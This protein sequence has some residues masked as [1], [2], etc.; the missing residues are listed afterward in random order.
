[1]KGI[2]GFGARKRDTPGENRYGRQSGR[3]KKLDSPVDVTDGFYIAIFD[4]SKIDRMDMDAEQDGV[5]TA[6]YL[7]EVTEFM[8]EGKMR[9]KQSLD[10]LCGALAYALG[11]KAPECAAQANG[12]LCGYIGGKLGSKKADR[13]FMYNP[14][15]IGN[16]GLL[17]NHVYRCAASGARH[18]VLCEAGDQD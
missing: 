11:I 10:T 2:D 1:M 15:A 8:Q 5:M 12:D 13:V 16:A 4:V 9:N 6:V 3:L 17:W 14:D 18:S 7:N